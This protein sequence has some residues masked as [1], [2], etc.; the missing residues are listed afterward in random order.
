MYSNLIPGCVTNTLSHGGVHFFGYLFFGLC[1]QNIKIVRTSY[2]NTGETSQSE[3]VDCSKV[4][5]V[6]RSR[7]GLSLTSSNVEFL[8]PQ[9]ARAKKGQLSFIYRKIPLIS[10][11]LIQ[12]R[13][14]FGGGLY[15]GGWTLNRNRKC[16]LKCINRKLLQHQS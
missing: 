9:N 16:V 6:P 7:W 3:V 12:L 10:P 2:R 13:M 8:P 15:P 4:T 5:F 11:G 14:G 1:L